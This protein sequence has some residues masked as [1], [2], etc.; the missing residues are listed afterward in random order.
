MVVPY[1]AGG[2]TDIIARVLMSKVSTGLGQ[3]VVLLNRP[4]ASGELGMDIVAHSRP[5]GYTV[6]FGNNGPNAIAPSVREKLGQQKLAYDPVRDF[7]PVALVAEQPLILVVNASSPAKTVN[8]FVR[9]AMAHPGAISFGST[10]IG[11]FSHVTGELFATAANVK[12]VHVP[13]KGAPEALQDLLAG[14]INSMFATYLDASPYLKSGKVIALAVSSINRLPFLPEVPAIA[15]TAIP[16]FS[17]VGWF[18]VLAPAGTPRVVVERLHQQI[19]TAA[20]LP[21]VREKLL[22]LG[23]IPAVSGPDQF[24]N[25]IKTD[26]AKWDALM[27]QPNV[28]LN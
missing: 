18:G 13:Y 4:G 28:N 26:V 9:E 10:G 19:A 3:P 2:T 11:S 22:S 17:A 20:S 1:P 6:G 12:L 8:D 25:R 27:K 24:A 14:R 15:E 21:D 16:R 23:F 5:D 7:Q